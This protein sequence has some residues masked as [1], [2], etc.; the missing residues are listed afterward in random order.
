M[1]FVGAGYQHGVD[2]ITSDGLDRIGGDIAR[3]AAFGHVA[4]ALQR[5]VAHHLKVCPRQVFGD[6]PGIVGAP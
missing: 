2:V 5:G 6:N 4:G 3:A 1:G